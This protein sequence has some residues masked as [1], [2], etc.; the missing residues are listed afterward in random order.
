LKQEK[1]TMNDRLYDDYRRDRLERG[2][3]DD[4][5]E[6]R[7]FGASGSRHRGDENRREYGAER[8]YSNYDE[9]RYNEPSSGGEWNQQ[10]AYGRGGREEYGSGPYEYSGM[11]RRD[12]D[13]GYGMERERDRYFGSRERG[14]GRDYGNRYSLGSSGEQQWGRGGE[15]RFA[16][17]SSYPRSHRGKG[18]SNYERSDE[19]VKELICERLSDDDDIDASG[20]SVT[21]SNGEAKLEGTVS[22]RREKYLVEDCA[23]QCG[24]KEIRNNLKIEARDDFGAGNDWRSGNRGA[25]DES[26]SGARSG[27]G[28]RSSSDQ[29]SAKSQNT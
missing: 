21:V 5:R 19:R 17:E 1:L 24:A 7:R 3:R 23:E 28:G 4:R 27:N 18:P 9:P 12:D 15:E 10:G 20:I 8:S 6:D 13:R 2:Y 26:R 25:A 14:Y 29:K 16:G 11:Q 22:S